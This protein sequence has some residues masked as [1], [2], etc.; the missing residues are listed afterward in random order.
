MS[1]DK[2]YQRALAAILSIS[3]GSLAAC[4]ASSGSSPSGSSTSTASALPLGT[5][6]VID[7]AAP[8]TGEETSATTDDADPDGANGRPDGGGPGGPGGFGNNC[9]ASGVAPAAAPAGAVPA[10]PDAGA[11]SAGVAAAQAFVASL[12]DVQRKAVIFAYADLDAK[13]CSWSNFPSGIFDGRQGVRMGDLAAPQ[14]AAALALVESLMSAGGY[15][16]TKAVMA[17][18]QVLATN[19]GDTNMGEDN[20]FLALYGDPSGDTAWTMQFGGHH[21]AIHISVGGGALSITPY[22]SGMQPISYESNGVTLEGMKVDADDMFGIFEAME[23]AQLAS[24][25]LAGQYDD[26]V[27]GPSVDTG[28]P[29]AEGAKF[30]DLTVAQQ[31]L[32]K[33][34]ISDWVADMAPGLSG[35]LVALYESQLDETTVGWSGSIDRQSGAYMR[36]DGP[37]VWIEW[38]N[39]TAGGG[40]HYHTIYR[41]KLLD[42]GTGTGG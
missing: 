1:T 24:A 35:P 38:V 41:D 2:K 5:V 31:S 32:V 13:R 21:L 14:R 23:P 25:K 34:A 42:Y 29:S 16:Y 22:F 30:S 33:A 3:V 40:L 18:D 27:M 6:A 36:I 20:Y 19:E 10:S 26:L 12:D 15:T 9:T 37:R 28:Y 39:T 4:A 11:V 7:T 17:G 8:T